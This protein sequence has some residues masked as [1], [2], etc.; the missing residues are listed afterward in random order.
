M[1]IVV[2]IFIDIV[3]ERFNMSFSNLFNLIFDILS[4]HKISIEVLFINSTIFH[5]H[6][7]SEDIYK[8]HSKG[9]LFLFALLQLFINAFSK[10]K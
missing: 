5:S 8:G 2:D 4:I 6:R 1:I 9:S 7:L 10:Y 3:L